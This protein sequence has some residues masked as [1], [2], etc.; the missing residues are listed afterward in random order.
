MLP[1]I[2]TLLTNPNNFSRPKHYYKCFPYALI[3]APTRELAIQI[4]TESE[5]VAFP[6]FSH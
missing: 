6:A 2:A 5:K 4:H 3:L 1:F